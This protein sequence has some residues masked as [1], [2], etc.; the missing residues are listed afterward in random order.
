MVIL[1]T[2]F[3]AT[4]VTVFLS[5]NSNTSKKEV[6]EEYKKIKHDMCRP[7]KWAYKEEKGLECNKCG[8]KP[9]F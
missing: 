4:F 9:E 6:E 5:I 3:L 7:H 1:L 8:F 2:I